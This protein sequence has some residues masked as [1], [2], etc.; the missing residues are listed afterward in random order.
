[1]KKPGWYE[2]K[3]LRVKGKL[4]APRHHR[5]AIGRQKFLKHTE[6]HLKSYKFYKHTG[7]G[8]YK[9][10]NRPADLP[11]YKIRGKYYFRDTRLNEYRNVYNPQDRIP[12][13]D[14]YPED[15]DKPTAEDSHKVYDRVVGERKKYLDKWSDRNI[16]GLIFS[17]NNNK[18]KY[19]DN[20][21]LYDK[22]D[23]QENDLKEYLKKRSPEYYKRMEEK[24][25]KGIY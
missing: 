21:K 20:K 24:H 17:M 23:K 18:F 13:D 11:V 15:F 2:K 5:A 6:R 19:I 9:A 10:L 22:F 4:V 12:I 8:K 3:T 16:E 14:V 25:K 1:M 7:R